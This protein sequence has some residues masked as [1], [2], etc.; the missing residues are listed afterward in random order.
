MWW[1][2][3]QWISLGFQWGKKIYTGW[4]TLSVDTTTVDIVYVDMSDSKKVVCHSLW[5]K[6]IAI[7]RGV[8]SP[9]IRV[10]VEKTFPCPAIPGTPYQCTPDERVVVSRL[11]RKGFGFVDRELY[12]TDCFIGTD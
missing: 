3:F 11:S 12:R 5:R 1:L 10:R 9:H 2:L 6:H 7:P 8:P 4:G